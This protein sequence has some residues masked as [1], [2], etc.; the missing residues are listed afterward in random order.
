MEMVNQDFKNK[1][2]SNSKKRHESAKNEI[3]KF[4]KNRRDISYIEDTE[5]FIKALIEISGL[6]ILET[7]KEIS[8]ESET[9]F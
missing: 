3:S 5:K 1:F 2:L 4:K 8:D 9:V 7:M 6:N